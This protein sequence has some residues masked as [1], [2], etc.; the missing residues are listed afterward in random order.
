MKIK[1]YFALGG[2]GLILL[3]QWTK[4]WVVTHLTLG[5]EIAFLPPL[6]GLTYLQNHGAAFSILQHQQGFFAVMT[7]LVLSYALYYFIK[8]NS[9]HWLMLTGLTL[10]MAGGLGNFIDRLRLGYVVDM[11]QLTFMDFAIF[12]V[13]DSYL[14]V[15]VMVLLVALWREE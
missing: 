3:D 15:G 9:S 13:A 7:I 2:L 11:I 8:Q 5:E 6:F 14:T 12:N 4:W 10:L 1:V